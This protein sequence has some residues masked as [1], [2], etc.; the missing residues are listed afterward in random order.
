MIRPIVSIYAFIASDNVSSFFYLSIVPDLQV[1]PN[2]SAGRDL[3]AR[4]HRFADRGEDYRLRRVH[5]CST[6]RG[7]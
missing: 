3:A 5:E 4:E 6:G 2:Q 7:H 1:L